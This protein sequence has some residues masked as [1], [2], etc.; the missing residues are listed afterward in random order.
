MISNLKRRQLNFCCA[1]CAEDGVRVVDSRLKEISL[2]G[3]TA[4]MKP[5][6]YCY[7]DFRRLMIGSSTEP[8][9]VGSLDLI[10]NK[11]GILTPGCSQQ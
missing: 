4:A 9:G 10:K 11:E 3:M 5:G 8:H 7:K 1:S 2:G 6:C